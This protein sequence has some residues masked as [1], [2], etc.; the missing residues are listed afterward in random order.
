MT[1]GNPN[2]ARRRFLAGSLVAGAGLLAACGPSS[3]LAANVPPANAAT[4][5][6]LP[7]EFKRGALGTVIGGGV[8]DVDGAKHFFIGIVDLDSDKPAVRTISDVGFLGHGFSPN[9][10]KPT[11]AVVCEKH[12][13]GCCEVD[14][15]KGKVLR[16]V[17]TTQ[18]REFYG[19]GAFT[20][21]GK[22]FYCTEAEVGDSSYAGV[23]AV[24]D[25]ESFE[26]RAENFPTHG[27][28]PHDCILVD[29][30]ATLVITNGG[31]PVSK[32]EEP[33]GIAYVD[34]K[35]GA[36]RRVLK[37]RD[38][39]INAGHIAI[40]PR[41]ELA[42]VSAPR[43]GIPQT[44]EGEPNP[45]WLGAISFYDPATDKLVTAEDPIRAKMKGETLS[46][47]IHVPS[48]V[49]AATNP[50]G[51][52]VTFW[53][54]KTGKLVHKI[55]GDLKW[56]RGISLTLDGNYFAVTYDRETRLVL[57]DAETFKPVAGT[58]IDRSFIS[59]SHNLVYRL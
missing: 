3:N 54:F 21:D 15:V 58:T 37:F 10:V 53:D 17:R 4:D 31:G 2:P 16:R 23:L 1:T 29:D 38:E 44:K 39:K 13:Q 42:C 34:V 46:V 48:M 35:T 18:G 36:A 20:P 8:A 22:L 26:L 49:V 45:A 19:H 14:L 50:A 7:R 56:P 43:E 41:G 24:R 11:T 27:V 52:L 47:A 30:G 59:G 12:G 6:K 33:A 57:L 32:P 40:T 28:A 25:G 55:E 51:D 9:P 5:P